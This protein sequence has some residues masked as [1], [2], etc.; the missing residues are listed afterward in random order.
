MERLIYNKVFDFLVRYEILFESQ[1]GFRKGHSTTHATLDFVR[2]LEDAID[3]NEFAIGVFCDLSKAFDTIDHNILLHKLNHYGIRGRALDWFTSYLSGREQYIDWNG[4][5]SD[6][7]PIL[8]G[9]PQ[10][11]ILGPLLFLIYINDLGTASNL[12]CVLFADDS[13]LLIQGKDLKMTVSNLN[14]E[15]EK[16]ND[17]FKSNKLKLNTKKIKLVCFRRKNQQINYD[18]F[19]I[20]LDGD[21]L[22]FEEEAIFLGITI[23]SHLS[24]ESQCSHVAS[25]I[26][27]SC[28]AI[29]RVKKLLPPSSLKILYSSL[30]LPH[31]QYGLAAWGG[32]S[33]QSRKRITAVQKRVI[34]VISKS[35]YMS[36]TEPRM[37]KFGLL[38]L[39]Q[40]YEQQSS[41]LI[42]DIIN[43]RAPKV[44]GNLI[45]LE[46]E[47]TSHNL[48]NHQSDPHQLR[49]PLARTKTS[50]NSLRTK[51]P[52][53]WNQLPNE[54]RSITSKSIFKSRLKQHYLEQ[55]RV[56]TECSNPRC[57]DRRHHHH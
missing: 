12:K 53:I 51:G 41:T 20:L 42:H 19:E 47:A 21:R 23:D 48:R 37:K 31:L 52:Q 43:K 2:A 11:S 26:S 55:Y 38:K 29:N 17:F 28:G 56:S 34:R 22:K 5:T 32:C 57:T 10:G 15:L 14:S 9:V 50:T 39:E 4:S 18:D 30:I 35:Y 33:G 6:R 44:M 54:L 13:N 16:I 8:T 49:P 36:H 27:R 45:N 3:R 40:L 1:F 24:W 25:K 46:R 7:L